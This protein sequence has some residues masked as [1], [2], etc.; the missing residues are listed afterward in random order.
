[1]SFKQAQKK[2]RPNERLFLYVHTAGLE[3]AHP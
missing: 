3:P 2:R 1:M